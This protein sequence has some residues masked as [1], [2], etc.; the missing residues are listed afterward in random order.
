MIT[1]IWRALIAIS[2]APPEPGRRVFGRGVV[3]DHGR[4][5]VA[6]AVDLGRAQEAD[7]DEP[8]LEVVGEEL[9][10]AHDGGGAR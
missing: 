2:Q 4:V 10:H 6:E 3:A 7:V 9:P 8:A 1:K 5:D